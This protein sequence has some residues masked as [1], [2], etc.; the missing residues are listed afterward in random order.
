MGTSGEAE[1]I[2]QII[3]SRDFR[4]KPQNVRMQQ[5]ISQAKSCGHNAFLFI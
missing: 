5:N 1:Q 4:P 2:C 3:E